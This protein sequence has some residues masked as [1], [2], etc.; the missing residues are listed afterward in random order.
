MSSIMGKNVKVSLFGESHGEAIGVVIDGL[1]AG[2]KLDL[3]DINKQM[4]RRRAKGAMSTARH[5]GDEIHIVSGFFNGYTTGTPLTILIHNTNTKSKDYAK[6]KDI[7]R[8]GHADYTAF[9]KYNGYQD[10]RGGGHFSG[11]LTAPIVA[12]GA[13]CEQILRSKGIEIGV[14]IK[15]LH[16][17]ED[18]GFSFEGDALRKEIKAMQASDFP[19]LNESKAKDM[20]A[21]ILKYKEEGNSV[22]GVLECAIIGMEPGI[23]E[24][25]AD[26]IESILSSLLFSVPAVKGVEF[27][28]GFGFAT[29]SGKEAN[30]EFYMD[31]N[32]VKTRTN[33]NG[34][35]NGGISNGMPITLRVCVKPTASIYKE[36]NSINYE[37]RSDSKLVI[38]G[39][40]DPAIIHR[41]AVV[42][43]SMI[44]IGLVDLYSQ[45][46]GYTWQSEECL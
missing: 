27:G 5:E 37:T 15:F 31:G 2:L 36:Q 29:M 35:I 22:G 9:E 18:D 26:S 25:F 6:T 38:E 13:I 41:A 28:A 7:V 23:G 40:H 1:D 24:P 46:Y 16:G 33:N 19:V 39:R 10:Y 21:E 34:G 44:A 8:P 32:T 17:I 11:R 14:H 12:A 3:D 30:D 45:R 20:E 42:V 4:D 43:E